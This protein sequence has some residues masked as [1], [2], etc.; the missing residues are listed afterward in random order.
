MWGPV[1][2][3]VG[4]PSHQIWT[5]GDRHTERDEIICDAMKQKK[6]GASAPTESKQRSRRVSWRG[7]LE[8]Y[9]GGISWRGIS[10]EGY[11]GGG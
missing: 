2:G 10:E 4:V 1:R 6:A 11:L 7:I 8:G 3:S 5:G 9:L